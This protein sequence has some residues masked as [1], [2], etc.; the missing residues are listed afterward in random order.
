VRLPRHI[1][2]ATADGSGVD[3]S[4]AEAAIDAGREVT[5]QVVRGVVAVIRSQDAPAA[6]YTD[7]AV[8][9]A[10]VLHECHTAAQLLHERLSLADATAYE[11]WLLRV[12]EGCAP[13]GEFLGGLRR[14][15]T[16]T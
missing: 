7:R 16:F 6:S 2:L 3:R 13:D 5:S 14:A 10:G 12:A 1:M 11:D 9:S 8:D 15:L 4:G